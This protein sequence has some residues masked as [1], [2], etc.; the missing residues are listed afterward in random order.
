MSCI[1][2]EDWEGHLLTPP[3]SAVHIRFTVPLVYGT[4]NH[5]P[6][7][8]KEKIPYTPVSLR[9]AIQSQGLIDDCTI[10]QGQHERASYLAERQIS[11]GTT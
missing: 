7:R 8:G 4:L 3:D 10:T 2:P 5:T 9:L 1:R 6:Y 11:R